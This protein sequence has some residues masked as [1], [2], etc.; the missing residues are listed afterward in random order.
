L[1][2]FGY[3]GR[4][5]R[6]GPI[7]EALAGMTE[8][9]QFRLD[10]FGTILNDEEQ[11]RAQIRA[12][13]LSGLVKV[14]GFVPE[15]KLESSL[16]NSALAINLRFPSVGEASGSQLRI[17]SHALP[18]LVSAVGWYASLPSN[19]VALVRTDENEVKDIRNHLRAFLTDPARFS[20]MGLK[21]LEELKTRH[22]PEAYAAQ[23]IDLAERAKNLRPQRGARALAKRAGASMGE[24]LVST[25]F[26]QPM[27]RAVDE[28]LSLVKR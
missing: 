13:K 8:K 7:L 20:E 25:E 6:L 9:D 2:L 26:D 10:I 19:T 12:L 27:Y 18:S 3:L 15:A 5:R 4:N 28:A 11:I 24:W 23:V 22:S 1:I 14:H 21:G 16:S 17:W